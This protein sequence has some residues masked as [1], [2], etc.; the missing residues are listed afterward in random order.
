M[1]GSSRRS[2]LA[3]ALAAA[4]VG[5]A[6]AA[7]T[8]PPLRVGL[9]PVF[10]DDQ[11]RFLK[12]WRAYLERRLQREVRFVQRGSYREIV[13]L[14]QQGQLDLAWLCGFPYVRYRAQ[15]RLLAVPLYHD[16]PL[17]ESY[18]IVPATDA[19]TRSILDLRGKVF[20]YS[21]PDS[22]SGF[23]FTQF[24]LQRLKESPASFFGKTFFT[25]GHRKV[26]E[27]VAV[28]LAQGG[29]V[30]GYVWDTLQLLYPTLT[31]RTRIVV[32]SPKFGF[33]PFVA[34]R[35]MAGDDFAAVRS[36]LLTMSADAQGRELLA[37][38]NLSGFTVGSDALFDSVQLMSR[39]I[40]TV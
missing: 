6:K 32:R 12:D 28:G 4:A 31:Q 11:A 33:P 36:V 35:S 38:L 40:G 13:D 24:E 26:V 15:L 20:A 17:Y 19:A 1:D 39:A 21:D 7:A 3:A 37:A 25:W 22:N 2:I 8:Q 5:D 34:R 30:D 9:T 29:A 14:L 27:A 23:L 18:L 16:Q 10:L